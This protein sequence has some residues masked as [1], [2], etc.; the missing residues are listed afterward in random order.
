MPQNSHRWVFFR[1]SGLDQAVLQDGADL[2]HLKELDKKLWV[3]LASPTKGLEFDTATLAFLDANK[4]GRIRLPEVLAAVDWALVRLK[5]PQSL[6]D[7]GDS[8]PLAAI[9][10]A[11]AEGRALMACAQRVLSWKGQSGTLS[12]PV[13]LAASELLAASRFNGDGIVTVE[14]AGD[15]RL[16]QAIADILSCGFSV[17][18]AS[19]KPGL[20][21]A[22]LAAFLEEARAYVAWHEEAESVAGTLP[23]GSETAKAYAALTAVREKVEDYFLR[24]RMHGFDGRLAGTLDPVSLEASALKPLSTSDTTLGSLPLARPREGGSL[25]F[26]GQLVNPAWAAALA[27]FAAATV[28]PLLGQGK[29]FGIAEADWREIQRRFQPYELWLSRKRDGKVEA[30]GLPRLRELLEPTL[31]QAIEA[32]IQKDLDHKDEKEALV[33]LERLLRY[34]ANLYRFL[35]NFVNLSDF[36][37]PGGTGIFQV[38]TL[39]IDGRACDL[40]FHVDDPAKHALFAA[41]SR[42]C[43]AY[44]ELARP[45]SGEKRQICAAVTAGMGDTLWVG[46]NGVFYDKAGNDWDATIVKIIEHPVSLRE[47]FWTPWRKIA[48]MIGEQ[49]R[50]F[51]AARET[52]TMQAASKNLDEVGKHTES[53]ASSAQPRLDGAAMASSIAAIGIAVGLLA[54]GFGAVTKALSESAMGW[55]QALLLGFFLVLLLVSGPSVVLAYLKMRSRDLSPILNACGWAVNGHLIMSLSI[56]RRLTRLAAVPEGAEH[57]LTDPYADPKWKRNLLI[58]GGLLLLVAFGEWKY[59]WLSGYV[60]PCVQSLWK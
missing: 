34:R 58:V 15:S 59:Q 10:D 29:S 40:C 60:V 13:V 25:A 32:L 17:V 43:L 22:V 1:R 48:A 46:R 24:C 39:Y 36:Y 27:E 4:D 41:N 7:G 47:A 9:N 57:R 14:T 11:S 21:S 33:D 45:A 28:I 3:A 38:G 16:A 54:S 23:L 44:C 35:C 56:G 5:D 2:V 19:G 12:L 20:D 31:S 55:D 26:Q 6:I 18:D 42:I 51:L 30:L 8:L 37:K 52:A 50:K 53:G 49:V